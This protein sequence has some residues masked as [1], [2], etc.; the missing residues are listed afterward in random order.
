M[1]KQSPRIRGMAL[2]VC[3]LLQV[4][5]ADAVAPGATDRDL[6]IIVPKADP[7]LPAARIHVTSQ[8]L[9]ANDPRAFARKGPMTDEIPPELEHQ[10]AWIERY[11]TVA[12][13]TGDAQQA[14]GTAVMSYFANNAE[15]TVD[16]RLRY[17]G[18]EVASTT[19][20]TGDSYLFPWRRSMYTQASLGISE[21]CGHMVDATSKHRVWDEFITSN[22][23]ALSWG[24]ETRSSYAGDSQSPCLRT[25][26]GGEGGGWGDQTWYIC[27]YYDWFDYFG[28]FLYREWVYCVPLNAE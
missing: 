1:Y 9:G 10:Q 24:S 15:Q 18:S 19:G 27:Y 23:G 4:A 20:I 14:Y 16:L 11:Y 3:G 13:F 2:A 21:A 17:N 6:D 28:N 12:G 5:C 25:G 7:K 22:Q 26:G 8:A